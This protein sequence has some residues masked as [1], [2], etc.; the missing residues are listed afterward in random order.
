MLKA[1]FPGTFD[2]PTFGHLELITRAQALCDHLVIGIGEN[3]SKTRSILTVEERK[4]ALQKALS[5]FPHV[6]VASFQG[7]T[8]D[9]AKKKGIRLLIRG[10]RS[11]DDLEYERELALANRKIS[12]NAVET[13]FL[14]AHDASYISSTLI[15]ELAFNGAPLK[16]FIPEELESILHLRMQKET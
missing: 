6:E 1:L 11:A 12:G 14:I 16:D 8:T 10:L 3:L 4:K 9:F 15:R 13:L 7:L 2:P 5:R